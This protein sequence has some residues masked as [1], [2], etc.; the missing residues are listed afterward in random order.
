MQWRSAVSFLESDQSLLSSRNSW[1]TPKCCGSFSCWGWTS[2]EWTMKPGLFNL[3]L[4][5]IIQAWYA[6]SFVSYHFAF[7]KVLIS[8]SQLTM[9]ENRWREEKQSGKCKIWYGIEKVMQ[10]ILEEL[11]CQIQSWW[12]WTLLTGKTSTRMAET[13]VRVL[14]LRV[15]KWRKWPQFKKGNHLLFRT[16]KIHRLGLCFPRFFFSFLVSFRN[17]ILKWFL[18][19]FTFIFCL[20]AF[21][22]LI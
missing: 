1:S 6:W 5:T 19:W 20:L 10:E 17:L 16:P 7:A 22:E 14:L 3:C 18:F 15:S 9:L 21:R 8:D 12:H 4:Q 13:V 11:S 2:F